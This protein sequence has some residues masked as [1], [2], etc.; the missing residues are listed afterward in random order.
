MSK[1]QK[2]HLKEVTLKN[3]DK[4]VFLNFSVFASREVKFGNTHYVQQDCGKDEQDQ[5]IKGPIIGNIKSNSL[6]S[7]VAPSQ[8]AESGGERDDIPF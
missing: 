4:A 6:S 1:I 3:G 2:R 7:G 8:P 5:W